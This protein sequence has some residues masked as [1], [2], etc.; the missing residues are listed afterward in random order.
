MA[1]GREETICHG[2]DAYNQKRNTSMEDNVGGTTKYRKKR[3]RKGVKEN[4]RSITGKY[5]LHHKA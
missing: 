2:L 1:K 3:G 4:N 5:F